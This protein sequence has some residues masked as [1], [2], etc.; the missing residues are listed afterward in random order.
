MINKRELIRGVS[1]V[2]YDSPFYLFIL[3]FDILIFLRVRLESRGGE[4][5]AHPFLLCVGVRNSEIQNSLNQNFD[6][7]EG[8]TKFWTHNE[9]D[10][11]AF[12][13]CVRA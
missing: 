6:R 7:N 2:R 9:E 1:G 3:K 10:N 8:A 13:I 4:G 5:V 12:Q 11:P